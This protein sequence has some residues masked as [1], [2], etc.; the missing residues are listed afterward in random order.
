VQSQI[1]TL[2]KWPMSTTN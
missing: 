2:Y 1:K